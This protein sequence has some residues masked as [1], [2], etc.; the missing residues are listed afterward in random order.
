MCS[1]QRNVSEIIRRMFKIEFK[2]QDLIKK[3]K[4]Y[5]IFLIIFWLRF[6]IIKYF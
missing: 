3:Y 4:K 2:N 6:N 1:D 5:I